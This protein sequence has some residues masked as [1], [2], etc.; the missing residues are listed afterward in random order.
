MILLLTKILFSS[1]Y[2]AETGVWFFTQVVF[3]RAVVSEANN[4]VINGYGSVSINASLALHL[5]FKYIEYT[6]IHV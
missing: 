2:Y 3:S 6:H 4:F 5:I 1:Y